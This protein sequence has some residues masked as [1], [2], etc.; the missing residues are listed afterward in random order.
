MVVENKIPNVSNLVKKQITMQKHQ[1][2]RLNISAHKCMG[3][4]LNAKAKKGLVDK[5][6]VSGFIDNSDLDKKD[7]TLAIKAVLKVNQDKTLKYGTFDSSYF[8]G[9]SPLKI[10]ARKVIQCFSHYKHFKGIVNC[11]HI[12]AKKF[13]GLFDKSIKPPVAS[14]NSSAPVLNHNNTKLGVKC[15]GSCLKQENVTFT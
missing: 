3:E 1:T 15:Y 4:I 14:N 12:S 11:N 2:L 7:A 5:Y 6:D 8:C 13:K 10:K 9:N